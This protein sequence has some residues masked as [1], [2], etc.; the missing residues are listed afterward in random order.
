MISSTTDLLSRWVDAIRKNDTAIISNLLTELEDCSLLLQ[1]TRFDTILTFAAS[2]GRVEIVRNLIRKIQS[3]VRIHNHSLVVSDY[4]DYETCRGKTPLVE[5]VKNNHASVVSLL[6]S[7]GA[8]PTMSTKMHNKSALS[9]ATAMGHDS[10]VKLINDHI[11]LE[12][13]VSIL[14]RAVST[15]DESKVKELIDGGAPYFHN[16]DEK[17]AQEL[18]LKC[19]QL[20]DAKQNVK[21]LLIALQEVNLSKASIFTKSNRD[22]AELKV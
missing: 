18:E 7:S 21:D 16:Q 17:Y 6:L 5:A 11:E 14:F 22:K 12:G 15:G 4:V 10:I 3:H 8:N 2:L 1:E 19:H 9:W 13:R 20:V